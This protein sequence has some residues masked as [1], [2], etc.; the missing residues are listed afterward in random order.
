LLTTIRKPETRARQGL[1]LGA[2]VVIALGFGLRVFRMA[3]F[4]LSGDEAFGARFIYLP[5]GDLIKSSASGDPHP[6]LFYF[7]LRPWAAV[8]GDGEY[9]L[10]FLSAATGLLVLP[11]TYRIGEWLFDSRVGLAA[12]LL[13]AVHPYQV[14]YAHEVRMYMPIAFLATL[15]VVCLIGRLR[16]RRARWLVGWGLATLLAM[17]THYYGITILAFANLLVIGWALVDTRREPARLVALW[18][19]L[20]GWLAANVVIGL[21]YLPWVKPPPG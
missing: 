10:R 17:Y 2:V 4:G 6:P 12:T 15:S 9:A 21:G 3:Q 8:F 11:L 7:A 20:R 5:L 19:A 13:L 16:Y 18:R 1:A 14:W